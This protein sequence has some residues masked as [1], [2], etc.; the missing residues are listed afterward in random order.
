MKV[1][2]PTTD[3]QTFY[4]IPRKYDITDTINFRDDQTNEVIIYTPTMVKENDFIKVTGV[5]DLREGH[6]YDLT[7]G[8]NYDIWNENDDFWDLSN[9]TWD[10]EKRVV[11]FAIDKVFCTAQVIDQNGQ[12]EYNINEGQFKTDNGFSN[13]YI[14]L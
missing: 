7:I 4:F 8:S 2:K 12:R 5:F 6:F 9:D 11:Y 13:D 1:L 14:V 3:E 10:E